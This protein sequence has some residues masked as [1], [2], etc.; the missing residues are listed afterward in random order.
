MR[1]LEDTKKE[2]LRKFLVLLL[3]AL[4][5]GGG[6]FA[7][8]LSFSYLTWKN[9]HATM[10]YHMPT[11]TGKYILKVITDPLGI[12]CV[13]VC[14]AVLALLSVIVYL[15]A[16]RAGTKKS[17]K[18]EKRNFSKSWKGIYGTAGWMTQKEFKKILERTKADKTKG[19]I[20]GK[21]DDKVVALPV[22][23]KYNQNMAVFG[24]SGSGKSFGFARPYIMQ[25]VERGE[26][27]FVTDPKSEL[28][29]TMSEFL[30]ANGYDVRQLNLVHHNNSDAWN[31]MEA[32]G[33]NE[34][35]LAVMCDVIIRN[36]GGGK[37]DPFFDNCEL[38]LLKAGVMLIQYNMPE[39]NRNLGTVYD[40]LLKD[41]NELNIMFADVKPGH[42]AFAP[43]QIFK[44]S[45]ETMQASA[46]VG[47]LTRL[48]VFQN[49][50]VKDLTSESDISLIKAGKEKCAYFCIT[51]DQ[52]ST[53]DFIGALFYSFA[54]IQLVKYADGSPDCKKGK[55]PRQ[56]KFVLDEFPNIGAIPDFCK[57][58][59]TVRSRGL[60]I[61]VIF[62]NLAQL[63]NRYPDGQWEEILGNC[64]TQLFLGCT[65]QTT[66][67][68]ISKRTG[69]VTVDVSSQ[70]KALK[71]LRLTDYTP[72]YRQS[73]S[74]GKRFLM[75]PDEVL[76]LEQQ[77]ALIFMKNNK[78]LEV[79]KFWT[80]DH[81]RYKELKDAEATAY[82]PE[83]IRRRAEEEEA[84]QQ[85][86]EETRAKR[87]KETKKMD[88]RMRGR[89]RTTP[90]DETV[91]Q[92]GEPD[93]TARK[94]GEGQTSSPLQSQ[95]SPPQSKPAVKNTAAET[96]VPAKPTET[97]KPVPDK[98]DTGAKP[99]TDLSVFLNAEAEEKKSA[100]TGIRQKH[101]NP[102]PKPVDNA[103]PEEPGTGTEPER[104]E[105]PGAEQNRQDQL[106]ESETAG[107][108]PKAK[109]NIS[110]PVSPPKSAEAA[111]NDEDDDDVVYTD[112]AEEKGEAGVLTETD[113]IAESLG[114]EKSSGD[115]N[116]D[117]LFGDI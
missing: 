100:T 112:S 54:F 77:H 51:S 16:M 47:L 94:S 93:V 89:G 91:Q 49:K 66:A 23:T 11:I 30:K 37:G 86:I 76:R 101:G 21:S 12:K 102:K 32:I 114:L 41:L 13:G 45:S 61:V 68:Y 39:K 14:V 28:Y 9:S 103:V 33:Q 34:T 27:I 92:H 88:E 18:D 70:A 99:K 59:S 113:I 81:P 40:T 105:E 38:N 90:A 19:T 78:P 2:L 83:R 55:L 6:T 110:E 1:I 22:D 3:T 8:L 26:S 74:V 50:S 104:T 5:V 43:Y 63:Q 116:I 87:E 80:Y 57:K 67:E 64:D 60:G 17:E 36:T 44:R 35:E 107:T 29:N 97:Q 108:E 75:T 106:A 98:T 31:V 56:V 84:L 117:D 24:G 72:E 82:V 115:V 58:I 20:L 95:V 62:Q 96:A 65:D 42:P 10:Y 73:E 48:G 111:E 46:R 15:L 52:D 85:R 4:T 79:E 7:G 109:P 25:C 69:E 53:F 71:T